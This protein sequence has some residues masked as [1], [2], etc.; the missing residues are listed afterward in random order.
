MPPHPC[1][2]VMEY[3]AGAEIHTYIFKG[4]FKILFW[5]EAFLHFVPEQMPWCS[6]PSKPCTGSKKKKCS[7]KLWKQLMSIRVSDRLG[8][9]CSSKPDL[10]ISVAR[11]L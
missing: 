6:P 4:T 8:L 9:T 7:P 11:I 10:G 5:G 2:Q 1:S 3:L